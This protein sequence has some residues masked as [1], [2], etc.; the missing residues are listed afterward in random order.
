MIRENKQKG[1]VYYQIHVFKDLSTIMN[2]NNSGNQQLEMFK[3][4]RN[5]KLGIITF[6]MTVSYFL[7]VQTWKSSSEIHLTCSISQLKTEIR[8]PQEENGT[9]AELQRDIYSPHEST[10]DMCITGNISALLKKGVTEPRRSLRV[11]KLGS[12]RKTIPTE[13]KFSDSPLPRPLW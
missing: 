11:V 8:G 2:W 5:T 9:V 13:V 12:W 7:T 10:N 6:W 1:T 3:R 4:R